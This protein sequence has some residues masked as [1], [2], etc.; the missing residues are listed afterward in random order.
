MQVSALAAIIASRA[1][2][3]RGREVKISQTHGIVNFR[4]FKIWWKKV[5]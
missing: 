1:A 2:M 5:R 3:K 4:I